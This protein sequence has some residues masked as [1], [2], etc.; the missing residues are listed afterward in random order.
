MNKYLLPIGLAFIFIGFI[1]VM[2]ASST[3]E[4]TQTKVAVGG[5]IGFVPFGFAND[6]TL[7][8]FVMI[9]TAV[10]FIFFVLIYLWR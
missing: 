10:V 1:I 2:I 8:Y 4:K 3:A 6:K 9:L 7:L 5:I